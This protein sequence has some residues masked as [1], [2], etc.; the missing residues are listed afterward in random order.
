MKRKIV[1]LINPVSG[2]RE[3]RTLKRIITEYTQQH[4][5]PFEILTTVKNGNY[6]FLDKKIRLEDITDVVICGGD[7]TVNQVVNLLL[8]VPVKFG[9]VPIGSGNGLAFAAGIP[10]APMKALDIIFHGRSK[11]TDA[12]TVN[13][14]F[15]CMLCGLGF[16]ALV[17]HQFAHAPKRGLVTYIKLTIKN[18]FSA[19]SFRFRINANDV[20]FSTDAYFISIA[21]SNQFGNNFTIAP[22]ADLGD[23]LLDV[24]IIKKM[25]KLMLL[26]SILQQVTSGK[27]R[28]LENSLRYPVIYFQTDNLEIVN[29][30]NAP[31]HIDGEPRSSGPSFNVKVLNQA[32]DLIHP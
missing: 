24:V 8:G 30:N 14:N 1:Y 16:D 31:I 17:A 18:F 20:L 25:P 29:E 10:K 11:K 28:R 15:A 9:I 22:Q 12:F 19:R 26:L 7:G 13:G 32:F 3:K 27:T 6:D 23:G 2:T 5:I 21:N 4:A